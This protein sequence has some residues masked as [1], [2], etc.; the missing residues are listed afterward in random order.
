MGHYPIFTV[1]MLIYRHVERIGEFLLP[2]NSFITYM[3]MKKYYP[4]ETV[5]I[6]IQSL[7]NNIQEKHL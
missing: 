4:D 7:V 2:P 1:V 6:N 3:T 5:N